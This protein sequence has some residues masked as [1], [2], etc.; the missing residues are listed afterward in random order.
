M[1]LTRFEINKARRGAKKLLGSPQAMHAAVMSAFAAANPGPD[2]RVLWRAD[3]G[4]VPTRRLI[5]RPT[6]AE[7]GKGDVDEGDLRVPYL[8]YHQEL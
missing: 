8:R 7:G 1:Y 5:V 3:A 4:E 2:G 6:K